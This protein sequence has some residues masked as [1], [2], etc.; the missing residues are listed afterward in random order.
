MGGE[1]SHYCTIPAP[2][3]SSKA[4]LARGCHLRIVSINYG[5]E[6]NDL[7]FASG[8]SLVSLLSLRATIFVF[9]YPEGEDGRSTPLPRLEIE[10]VN[11]EDVEAALRHTKPSA[12]QLKDKYKDWQKEYESV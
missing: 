2:T 9:A 3:Y 12:R 1:C 4:P 7:S 11:T 6:P 10:P 8:L 5:V